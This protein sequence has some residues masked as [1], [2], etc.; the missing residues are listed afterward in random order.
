[1]IVHNVSMGKS[2]VATL[3]ETIAIII[4]A[5][6]TGEAVLLL[7]LA[8]LILKHTVVNFLGQTLI[9]L[10]TISLVRVWCKN[11]ISAV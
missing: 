7:T 6:V 10:Q 3:L 4:L 2:I 1:M 11:D 9:S 8:Y 5:L